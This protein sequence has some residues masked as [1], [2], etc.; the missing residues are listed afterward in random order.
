MAA[1]E[2]KA[3]LDQLMGGDRDQALPSGAALPHKRGSGDAALLLPGKRHKS[4]YDKLNCPLFCAW[5]IDVYE[6]F[7]NTKSDI[8]PNPYTTDESARQEYNKNST[9]NYNECRK[10]E[11]GKIMCKMSMSL[12]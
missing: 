6:L 12:L 7:V 3:L 1:A 9:R 5:G 2:A 10:N 8:G 4:C 11:G